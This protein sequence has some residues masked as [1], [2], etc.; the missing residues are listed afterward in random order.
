MPGGLMQLLAWGNQNMYLNGNPNITFFKKV[1]K[2]HTNFSMESIRINF[3]RND[4]LINDKTMLKATIDRHGDLVAQ[5]YF[6]LE[7]PDITFDE[8]HLFKWVDYV[9]ESV[10]D[11]CQISI[12]GNVIDK[13]TG[14]FKHLY[15]NLSYG[16]DKQY[17][18]EKMTGHR[19]EIPTKQNPYTPYGSIIQTYSPKFIK[20]RKIYIP[21]NFWCNRT[22]AQAIPLIGLQYSEIEVSIELRPF[23]E[24]YKIY[25]V[26]NGISDFYAPNLNVQSHLL[27]AFV[28]NNNKR[29]LIS[30]NVLDIKAHL[31]VNYVFLDKPERKHFAYNP[32]EYLIEQTTK[33][34]KFNVPQNGVH[35]LILQNPVK[36]IMWVCSRTDRAIRNDWFT[37]TDGTE[38][39]LDSAKLM[40]NG[41]DR[42]DEKDAVYF[43]YV[44]PFQHHRANYKDGLYVYS[45]AINADDFEQ[46]SGSCNCS[47]INKIQMYL[48][49]KKPNDN[50]YN[51]DVTF[52]VTSYN[53]LRV[54]K[55]LG[56]IAFSK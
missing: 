43:N 31:E 3:N 14:E 17:M 51:Y 49:T 24:L 55:G 7:L 19:Y 41:L 1:Y 53:L 6:V 48:S 21:L 37:Y 12:N 44:Q 28:D 52:Y 8:E 27:S 42:F 50:T 30:N 29:Y 46:P 2:T 54:E 40:F 47:L 4:V 33:I 5:M 26:K 9:G 45:F 15:H 22:L 16:A 18:L 35:D 36:E 32:L 39:I 13:Q 20:S 10:I 38:Q 34:D 25:Y 11:N 56:S 23:T